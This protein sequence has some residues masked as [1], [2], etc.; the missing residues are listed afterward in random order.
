MPDKT[1]IC[2]LTRGRMRIH[3]RNLSRES[4]ELC[5]F[6]FK[7]DAEEKAAAHLNLQAAQ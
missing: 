6:F 5:N 1:V 4:V 7:K 3:F 2:Q